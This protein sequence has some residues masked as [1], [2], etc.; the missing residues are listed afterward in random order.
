M[1]NNQF[2]KKEKKYGKMKNE[3]N[4]KI[5]KESCRTY[6]R[7]GLRLLYSVARGKKVGKPLPMQWVSLTEYHCTTVKKRLYD[8]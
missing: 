4:K 6:L 3:L 5:R 8:G 7:K 2:V 1:D